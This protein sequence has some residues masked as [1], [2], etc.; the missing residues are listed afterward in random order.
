MLVY[1]EGQSVS[2]SQNLS[3]E[4]LYVSSTFLHRPDLFGRTARLTLTVCDGFD[5]LTAEFPFVVQRGLLTDVVFG[6][7]WCAYRRDSAVHHNV[8]LPLS[9]DASQAGSSMDVD[10]TQA[11][12]QIYVQETPRK[13]ARFFIVCLLVGTAFLV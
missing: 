8:S 5:S 6:S 10:A 9:D 4:C 7:D 2:F 11:P 12:L 13:F 3:V 1:V